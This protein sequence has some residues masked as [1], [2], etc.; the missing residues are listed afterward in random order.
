MELYILAVAGI[1]IHFLKKIYEARKKSTK[2][3]YVL[4]T[5]SISISIIIVIAL[6]FSKEDLE[7]LYPITKLTALL[8]GYTA[9]STFRF[10][11]NNVGNNNS[12]K[13]STL[14]HPDPDKEEK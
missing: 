4:E 11:V 1:I 12:A 13:N 9:Q 7:A 8:L 2:L 14:G 3:D 10:L 5:I 6:I